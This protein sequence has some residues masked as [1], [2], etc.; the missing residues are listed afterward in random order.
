LCGKAHILGFPFGYGYFNVC[1]EVLNCVLAFFAIVAVIQNIKIKDL[2]VNHAI[3]QPYP[4][5]KGKIIVL[6]WFQIFP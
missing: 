2:Q 4:P 6:Y 1:C 3:N 5:S